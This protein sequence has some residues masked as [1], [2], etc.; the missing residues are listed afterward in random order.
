MISP[1]SMREILGSFVLAFPLLLGA[2][3]AC[4]S[5]TTDGAAG[6]SGSGGNAGTSGSSGTGGTAG[7]SGSSGS[8]GTGGTGGTAGSAC[9]GTCR[10]NLDCAELQYCVTSTLS[11]EPACTGL[12]FCQGAGGDAGCESDVPCSEGTMC[13]RMTGGNCACADDGHM[14]CSSEYGEA[15]ACPALEPNNGDPCIHDGLRCYYPACSADIVDEISCGSGSWSGRPASCPSDSPRGCPT[16]VPTAGESCSKDGLTCEY[17][18]TALYPLDSGLA[19]A[20]CISGA[21]DISRDVVVNPPSPSLSCDPSGA[22]S[23]SY[24]NVPADSWCD[25]PGG[26]TITIT[27]VGNS[28]YWNVDSDHPNVASALISP[29]GCLLTLLLTQDTSNPSETYHHEEQITIDFSS[30]PATVSLKYTLQGGSNCSIEGAPTISS[31]L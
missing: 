28:H 27:P 8:S 22:W 2:S 20:V 24:A 5:D 23:L 9:D 11:T 6:S 1:T 18:S 16:A 25:F 12:G 19:H 7:S 30:T 3:S 21:W 13:T 29:T 26:R 15:I 10:S 17:S 14:H 31:V 4:S